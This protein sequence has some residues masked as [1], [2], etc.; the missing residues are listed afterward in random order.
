M[1]VWAELRV[2]DGAIVSI[3]LA[4]SQTGGSVPEAGSLVTRS[5]E[6]SLTVRAE[7]NRQNL[8]RMLNRFGSD[9]GVIG[10]RIRIDR[11]PYTV[12]GIVAGGFQVLAPSEAWTLVTTSFMRSQRASRTNSKSLV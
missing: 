10:R 2:P 1:S 5:R 9:P 3:G 11:D 12:V 4:D 8:T 6:N 7:L